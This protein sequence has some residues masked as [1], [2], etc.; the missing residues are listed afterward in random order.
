M[1][2]NFAKRKKVVAAAMSTML[3]ATAFSAPGGCN[4]TIDEDLL[5]QVFG[6]VQGFDHQ[7]FGSG[8]VPGWSE[9]EC[10]GSQPECQGVG[11]DGG[12]DDE[13]WEDNWQDAGALMPLAR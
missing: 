1:L 10:G 3:V 11:D 2:K 8:E 9:G 6:F 7:G 13:G 4:V 5:Q 12:W